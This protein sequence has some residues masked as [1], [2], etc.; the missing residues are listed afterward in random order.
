MLMDND[1]GTMKG[2]G[3]GLIQGSIPEF[4]CRCWE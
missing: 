3:R 2:I 1:L 4:P